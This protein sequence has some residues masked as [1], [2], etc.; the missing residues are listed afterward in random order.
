MKE[1][2]AKRT[3]LATLHTGP[4]PPT[5][6]ETFLS[7]GKRAEAKANLESK[8]AAGPQEERKVDDVPEPEGHGGGDNGG[9][10]WTCS[11]C[12]ETFSLPDDEW[13]ARHRAEHE[14][15][16]YAADLQAQYGS[17]GSAPRASSEKGGGRPKKKAEKP[18]GIKAFFAPKK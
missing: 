5:P 7:K 6:L 10:G 4:K 2:L 13:V 17:G 8:Y 3:R 14:D 12:R 9:A 1:P 16:H 15:W 11:R 18:S